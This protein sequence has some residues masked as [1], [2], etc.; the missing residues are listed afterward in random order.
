[1]ELR[2]YQR[3]L[4]N[5]ACNQ[6]TLVVLPTGLGKTHVALAL[7][8]KF[9]NEKKKCLFLAPTKP[10]AIQH[11]NKIKSELGLE[12][13]LLTGEMKPQERSTYYDEQIIVATP[14]CIENDLPFLVKTRRKFDLII[15]D[16]AHRAAGDYAYVPI[17]Q[18]HEGLVLALTA[19]PYSDKQKYA[20]LL[21]NLKIKVVESR[22]GDEIDVKDYSKEIES[23]IIYFNFPTYFHDVY[24][25]L[26]ELKKPPLNFL[27]AKGF[28]KTLNPPRKLLLAMQP[29]IVRMDT[30]LKYNAL[31]QNAILLN[32]LLMEELLQTQTASTLKSFIET[33]R[34]RKNESKAALDLASNPLLSKI[35]A[36]LLDL[37]TRGL[38]HPKLLNLSDLV[39]EAVKDNHN[40]LI[41]AHYRDTIQVIKRELAL[42]GIISQEL[43]GKSNNGMNQK[44]QAQ[45]IED[46]RDK[47]FNVL[48]ATSIGEEGLDITNVDTVIFYDNVASEIR[49]VQRRG[50]T[51]RIKTG[52]LKILVTKDSIDEAYLWAGKNKEKK[53]VKTMESHEKQRQLFL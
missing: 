23:E 8:Q 52:K 27:Y 5:I 28:V 36:T 14:Q 33:L 7:I 34:G 40:C 6:N 32:V 16:E 9:Y 51:A 13:I 37:L 31:K 42:N 26:E 25:M 12:A 47:K 44:Q 22:K 4:F 3:N 50:R 18:W 29:I 41:F 15:F 24:S 49:L 38:E 19:S 21:S 43:V 20:E 45:I 46:F 11:V 53:V 17:S 10:L 35:E 2:E 1:M 48:L 30:P 39:K